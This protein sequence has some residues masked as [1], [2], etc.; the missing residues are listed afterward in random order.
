M[1]IRRDGVVGVLFMCAFS[2]QAQALEYSWN[3]INFTLNN[4]LSFG[5]SMRMEDRDDDLIGKLNVEGQQ[6]LCAAD[7]CL[8][9]SGDPGPNQRLVDAKGA[10]LG[11]VYDD[12]NLN[13]DKH[14]ITSAATKLNS[15][16]AVTWNNWA[17]K[18]RGIAFYDTVNR[19]RDDFHTNTIHQPAETPRLASVERDLGTD[20]DLL[21]AFVSGAFQFGERNLSVSV[22]K[23]ILRWGET[24]FIA[25]N[26]LNEI[27]PPDENRL[28]LPGSEIKDVFQPVPMVLISA[29]IVPNVGAEFF[30]QYGWRPV[31]PAGA[32][33]FL[34]GFE[35]AG[36]QDHAVVTLGQTPED[37]NGQHRFAGIAAQ[38][39]SS[40]AT[41][42]VLDGFGEPDD[43]GQYGLRVNYFAEK[44]NGGTEFGFYAANYHSRFPYLGVLAAQDSCLRN[45]ITIVDAAVA[46]QGFNGPLNPLPGGEPLPFDTIKLFLDYPE[47]IKLYGMS[48][49][50]N[51]GSWSLAGEYAYRPEMPV[52]VALTDV[53]MA[54]GQPGFPRQDIFAGLGTIPG[55][56]SITPDFLSVY[57][58]FDNSDPDRDINGGQLIRGF[59]ELKVGQLDLTAL[60]TIS[61]SNPIGA[62]QIILLVEVG[63]THVIDMPDQDELQFEGYVLHKNTHASAGADGTGSGGVPD[64]RRLNPTQQTEGFADDFAWG[65]RVLS[66]FEYNDVF[67]GINFKPLVGWFHD[68]NG[69]A[70]GPAQNFIEGRKNFLVGTEFDLEG[71]WSGQLSYY[72]FKGDNNVLR[73]R[74]FLNFSMSYTF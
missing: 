71:G 47:D 2:G 39:S 28:L 72:G 7:D 74:D 59:E 55:A 48:F 42:Q 69:I 58:G 26:G 27:N 63:I 38:L 24:N 70:V 34:S 37:P 67:D 73:D 5:G 6:N 22:G 23:Q 41:A 45:S 65:Y 4:R 1:R 32:G 30:Y 15:E 44:L 10:F 56:R 12:G 60:K 16:L 66:R 33:G 14:D 17:L 51:L 29:D 35:V 25:L 46:C 3:D 64:S 9:F 68:V 21:D 54:A 40:S 53:V 19:G 36:G 50:T 61:S 52:Q 11:H 31:I 43:G 18:A 20:V 49:N 8:S 62:D 13:Y 57:R